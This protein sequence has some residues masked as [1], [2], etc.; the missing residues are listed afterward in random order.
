MVKSTHHR[1]V[2]KQPI[3]IGWKETID[4]PE[5]GIH[6]L[7]AKSDTGAKSSAIDVRDI[8]ELGEGRVR[9]VIYADRKNKQLKREVEA[10]VVMETKVRSSNGQLQRRIKVE[11][12]LQIGPVKKRVV[13]SLVN[14]H[15]MICRALLGRDALAGSFVVDSE[16]KYLHG[17]RRKPRIIEH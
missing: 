8:E 10:D 4:L 6:E 9:F 1:R 13:F 11:T 15:R 3:P 7:V 14:R 12:L 16:K 17:P 2:P 5:W